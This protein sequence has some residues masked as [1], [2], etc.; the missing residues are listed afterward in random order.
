MAAPKTLELQQQRLPCGGGH[1]RLRQGQPGHV[2]YLHKGSLCE[3]VHEGR[4]DHQDGLH[5]QLW[6]SARYLLASHLPLR[7]SCFRNFYPRRLFPAARA[8]SLRLH[9]TFTL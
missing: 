7:Q 5:C 6:W 1:P 3:E 4:E 9:S 2:Q 8:G